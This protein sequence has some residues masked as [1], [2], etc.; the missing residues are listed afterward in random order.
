MAAAPLVA[1]KIDCFYVYPTVSTQTTANANLT[2]DPQETAVAKA[3]ASRFSQA[4]AVYAPMYRQLTVGAITGLVPV[5]AANRAVAYGDVLDAW[6]YYLAHYNHGRGVAFIGHSQGS[7]MLIA[8]LKSQI[9]P[10]PV[11]RSRMVSAILLGGNVT[12][13]DGET[14]G[15][16]FQHIPVCTDVGRPGCV[17]AYSS[18]DQTP[19]ANSLFG[20]VDSPINALSGETP[21][22]QSH[23]VCVNPVVGT[24]D[25]SGSGAGGTPGNLI[26]YFPTS[27]FPNPAGSSSRR[28]ASASTI[29]TPWVTYPHLYRAQCMS[30]GGATW[31]QVDDIAGPNDN[32]PVVQQA[33]GPAWGL[34]LVDVNIALGNLVLDLQH[35][36]NRY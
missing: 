32:R 36:T 19:P 17:I 26:P 3:Q 9:D 11:L 22:A 30:Q 15:G 28:G 27:S 8:L 35:Q 31:L 21:S 20:R 4:C 5:T 33:L 24:N 16:T 10:N 23:V 7:A 1:P 6:K 13:P 34:H 12:V 29:T 2:I 18:F 25:S 14:L